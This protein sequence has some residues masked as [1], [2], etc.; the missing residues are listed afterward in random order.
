MHTFPVLT[1]DSAPARSRPA[2]EALQSAFGFVPNV[3]GTMASSPVLIT[4]LVS[5]FRNVHGGSFSEKQ[6]QVALLT[7][8]VTNVCPWAVALHSFLALKEGIAPEDV[9]AI[10][11]SELPG[12]PTLAALSNLARTLIGKRGRLTEQDIDAFLGAGFSQ[13]LLLEVIAIV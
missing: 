9:K 13:E 2:L 1:L 4:S 11:L 6:I 8:A 7:N 3:A 10:R 5:L 12:D